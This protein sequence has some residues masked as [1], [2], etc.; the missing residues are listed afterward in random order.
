MEHTYNCDRLSTK[1]TEE[2]YKNELQLQKL[3]SNIWYKSHECN[4]KEGQQHRKAMS[5]TTHDSDDVAIVSMEIN[6]LMN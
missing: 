2:S 1:S 3:H 6:T 4:K 5:N